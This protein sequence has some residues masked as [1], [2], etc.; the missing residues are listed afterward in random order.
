[1]Y[2][3]IELV[4]LIFIKYRIVGGLFVGGKLPERFKNVELLRFL[5]ACMVV[6][7][8]CGGSAWGKNMIAHYPGLIRGN[9]CVDFFFIIAVFFLFKSFDSLQDTFDFAKKKF[10]RLAPNVWLLLLIVMIASVF[11]KDVPFNFTDSIPRL[12]LFSNLGL[13]GNG[14]NNWIIDI[15]WFSSVIFWVSVFYFYICKIFN[16]KYINLIMWLTIFVG[17]SLYSTIK[18]LSSTGGHTKIYYHWVNIGV[19]RAL[20]GMSIGYFLSMLYKTN[21]LKNCSKLGVFF[22]SCLEVYLV[23]FFIHYMIYSNTMPAGSLFVFCFLFS[24]LFYCLLVKQGIISRLANN[25]FSAKL[26]HYSYAIYLFHW[27]VLAWFRI[28]VFPAHKEYALSHPI[29]FTAM[30][31]CISI[32]ISIPVY[33]FYEKPIYKFLKDRFIYKKPD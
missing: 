26:G 1:M 20:A 19:L 8:H 10:F 15:T 14:R 18:G 11:I 4:V 33:H 12:F 29:L 23:S 22:I 2:H 24:V 30:I 16:K 7:F 6:I 17:Y 3:Y 32:M 21:S 25:V 13:A 9:L 5:L 28:G 27:L 31:L